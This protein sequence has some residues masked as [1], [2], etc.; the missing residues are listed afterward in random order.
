[1]RSLMPKQADHLT[2]QGR[3]AFKVVL[4]AGSDLAKDNLLSGAS[5]Q[6]SPD[7]V[8]QFAAGQEELVFGRQLHGVA[9]GGA[10]ARDDADL[11]D[12]IGVL[13]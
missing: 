1:M 10:A 3:G 5:A 4:R 2:G 9:Q 7:P 6:Q 8:E 13:L 12:R 11:V